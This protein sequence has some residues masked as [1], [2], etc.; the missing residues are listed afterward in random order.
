MTKKR[1]FRILALFALIFLAI[2]FW[3]DHQLKQAQNQFAKLDKAESIFVLYQ[4]RLVNY[5]LK[6]NQFKKTGEVTLSKELSNENLDYATFGNLLLFSKGH[7][8]SPKSQFKIA[9]IDLESGA[10][11]E[12]KRECLPTTGAGQDAVYFYTMTSRVGSGTQIQQFDTAGKK[13]N[14]TFLE[15][16]SIGS[17]IIGF[18]DTILMLAGVED[19]TQSETRYPS[20]ISVFKQADLS[21]VTDYQFDNPADDY[22]LDIANMENIGNKLYLPVSVKS[23]KHTP[24]YVPGSELLIFDLVTKEQTFIQLE[25]NYPTGILKDTSETFL[26]IGHEQSMLGKGVVSTYNLQTQKISTIRIKDL[27]TGIPENELLYSVHPIYDDKT[28]YDD[29]MVVLLNEYLILYDL[30]TNQILDTLETPFKESDSA[31]YVVTTSS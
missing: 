7:V 25:E 3:R 4:D 24:D 2:Y 13:V 16:E 17:K 9:S 19:T 5:N 30:R 12:T 8:T 10:Y 20:K 21:F 27:V 11:K 6:N 26:V 23:H 15:A 18:Q 22:L 14:E 31:L 28:I 29:K 1:I